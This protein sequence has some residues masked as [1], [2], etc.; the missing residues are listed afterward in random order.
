MSIALRPSGVSRDRDGSA[1]PDIAVL[2]ELVRRAADSGL[3][4]ALRLEGDRETLPEVVS[5]TAYRIVQEGLTNALRHAPGASV[6]VLVRGERERLV[7]EVVNGAATRQG[8]LSD[9]GTQ[10]GLTGLRERVDA[11]GGGLTAGPTADGGWRL[12][13]RLKRGPSSRAA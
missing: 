3:E 8:P 12:A 13:A 2:E 7:V 9:V 10:T 1:T 11:V 4:V 6:D 5:R